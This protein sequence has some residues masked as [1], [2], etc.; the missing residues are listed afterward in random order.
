MYL[1]AVQKLSTVAANYSGSTGPS[2]RMTTLVAKCGLHGVM[3][4]TY[5]L[6]STDEA[7]GDFAFGRGSSVGGVHCFV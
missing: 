2:P 6:K 3:H 4:T 5:H 7:N 1:H